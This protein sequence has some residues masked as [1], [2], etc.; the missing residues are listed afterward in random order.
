MTYNAFANTDQTLV[1]LIDGQRLPIIG[2]GSSGWPIT[3]VRRRSD[4]LPPVLDTKTNLVYTYNPQTGLT[5]IEQYEE[6]IHG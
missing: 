4:A 6:S 3:F 5:T 2:W 1:V